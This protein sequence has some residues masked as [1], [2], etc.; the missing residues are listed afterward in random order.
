MWNSSLE[1]CSMLLR[2]GGCLVETYPVLVLSNLLHL[3]P[4]GALTLG[5]L[6][7]DLGDRERGIERDRKR[8]GERSQK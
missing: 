6:P 1:H 3:E 8:N 5:H 7:G 2:S 4:L